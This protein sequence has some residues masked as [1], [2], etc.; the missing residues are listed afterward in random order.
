MTMDHDE[1][2]ARDRAG[3][4]ALEALCAR[5]SCDW[6]LDL[7]APRPVVTLHRAGVF[8]A[9]AAGDTLADAVRAH[10]EIYADAPAPTTPDRGPLRPDAIYRVDPHPRASASD[11]VWITRRAG[12]SAE[13]VRDYAEAAALDPSRVAV[14]FFLTTDPRECPADCLEG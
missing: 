4:D 6:S 3:R 10:A 12:I 11:V 13:T 5:L 14:R 7:T 8:L 9:S 2:I 1:E